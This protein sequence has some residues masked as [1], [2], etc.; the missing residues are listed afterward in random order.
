MSKRILYLT[1][2]IYYPKIKA[3]SRN[4]TGLGMVAWEIAKQFAAR[5]DEVYILTSTFCN[6]C[7]VEGVNI[8]GLSIGN[9]FKNAKYSKLL[10][11]LFLL[12][13]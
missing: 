1:N 11:Y 6:S 10:I 9:L 12:C 13:L 2:Y 3:F 8:I 7:K 5:G 4:K